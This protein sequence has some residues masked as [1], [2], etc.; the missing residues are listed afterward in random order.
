MLEVVRAKHEADRVDGHVRVF[1][2]ALVCEN[3]ERRH[4]IAMRD[5][6]GDMDRFKKATIQCLA[7]PFLMRDARLVLIHTISDQAYVGQGFRPDNK[8]RISWSDRINLLLD[9]CL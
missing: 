9:R 3:S 8:R 5:H 1:R 7:H 2:K 4:R 6:S